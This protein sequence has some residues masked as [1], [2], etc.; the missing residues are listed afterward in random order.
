[1]DVDNV[2]AP[3]LV[4]RQHMALLVE[5]IDVVVDTSIVSILLKPRKSS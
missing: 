2:Y 3:D 1:V 5:E 4:L